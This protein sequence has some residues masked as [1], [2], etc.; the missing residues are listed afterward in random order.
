[1]Q[2]PHTQ[3]RCGLTRNQLLRLIAPVAALVPVAHAADVFKANNAD[4]LNI[5]TSWVGGALPTATDVA[6]F[7]STVVS[8]VPTE[9]TTVS[10]SVFR[11][12][13]TFPAAASFK[14][15]RVANA[16]G[17]NLAIDSYLQGLPALSIG[18]SGLDLS[19]AASG[20]IFQMYGQ[21][22]TLTA[23]QKWIVGDGATLDLTG[24]SVARTT[25]AGIMLQIQRGTTSTG[26]VKPS[27]T[28]G[29]GGL[30]LGG[31]A[32]IDGADFAGTSTD[33]S[34]VV[35]GNTIAGLYTANPTAVPP[36]VSGSY[37]V[38]DIVNSGTGATSTALRI[39]NTT[40]L[41]GIHFN[42]AHNTGLD[43][44]I[45]GTG[46]AR[47]I[48][49]GGGGLVV[50]PNVGAHNVVFN[51]A[52]QFRFGTNSDFYIHQF[53]TAGDLVL[54]NPMNQSNGT[55]TR[56]NKDGP[57]RL[58]IGSNN[59]T[60]GGQTTIFEGTIQVGN[61]GAAGSINSG[62]VANFGTLAFNRTDAWTQAN[63]IS[64]TGAIQML[65]TGTLTLSGTNTFTGSLSIN[66]G[67]VAF[68]ATA[69]LGAATGPINFNGGGLQ[70]TGTTNSTDIS[71]RTV[72]LASTAA[73]D[74]GANNVTFANPVGNSGAGGL[75]K[76]GTGTLTLAAA[77]LYSGNTA[78]TS[79]GLAV[80]NSTGS[81]TGSGNVSVA[82]SAV[83]SGTGTISG[84]V[85]VALGGKIKPGVSGVGTLTVGGL[86]M[87]S[88]SLMDLEFTSLSSFDKVVV[89]GTNGLSLDGVSLVLNPT[90]TSNSLSTL[91]NYDVLQYAGSIGGAGVSS[92]NVFNPQPGLSY[93]FT[94]SGGVVTLAVTNNGV[95]PEW[96]AGGS[97]SWGGTSNWSDPTAA[98][99]GGN[100]TAV[101]SAALGSVAT[102]TLDGDRQTKG[103]SFGGSGGYTIAQGTGGSLTLDNG[104]TPAG[105]TVSAG[106]HTISAP[107]ILNSTLGA[108]V[109]AGLNLQ[110]SG[111]VSGS[112]GVNKAGA[113]ILDLTGNNSFSGNVN[114]VAGILGFA[115][116]SSLGSGTLTLSGGA[117]RY[118]TGNTADIS[119]KVI[120]FGINGA[121]IDTNGNSLTLVNPIGNAG[122]G[123]FTKSGAGVLTLGA[124]NT[125]TGQTFVT[126]G[127]LRISANANLGDP[128]TGAK[129]TLDGS[130]LVPTTTLTLDN[131]GANARALAIGGSGAEINV[132]TGLGLTVPGVMTGAGT[133]LKSGAGDLTLSGLNS[134]FSGAVTIGAGAVR[135]GAVAASGQ[136]GLGT[137][138]ITFGNGTS[139]YLNGQGLTDN[140]TSYG[141][142]TNALVVSTG[143][144]ANLYG[145]QRGGF[146]GVVTGAG[147]LNL[148]VDGTRFDMNGIWPAFTGVMNVSATGSGTDDYRLN[149]DHNLSAATVNIGAGVQ[150]YQVNNPPA[151]NTGSIHQFGA[152]NV[153]AAATLA[154]N[155]VGGR[156][157]VY[158]IG[159][160]NANSVINGHI[161]GTLTS[162]A[163]GYPFI[164]KVG[165][166]TLTI[167]STG[168]MI[169]TSTPTTV[170]SLNV[171]AGTLKLMGSI[172]R[173]YTGIGA[174]G[175]YGRN[176]NVN[177]VAC[178]DTNTLTPPATDYV[179]SDPGACVVAAGATLAGNGRFGGL[180]TINGTLRPDA[181]GLLGGRLAFTNAATLTLTASAVTQFDFS[182]NSFTGISC[183]AASGV[184]VGGVLKVN[185]LNTIYNGSYTL[186]QMNGAP[187]GAFT[188]VTITTTTD[189]DVPLTDPTATGVWTGTVGSVTYTFTRS[190]G[191]LEVSGG[192]TVVLPSAVTGLAATAGNAQVAL[193]W[194]ASSN[195]DSYLVKRSTVASGPYT[196][197]NNNAALAYTDTG[198]T[199]GTTYYYVVEAKNTLGT[200]GNSAEVFATP[201]AAPVLNGLETWRQAQ[202]G[203]GATNTGSAA[204]NA[205]PDGDGMVNFLEYATNHNPLVAD[206]PA[207]LIGT[208]SGSLTLTY[209]TVLD[210]K[211]TYTVQGVNDITG[212]PV[213]TT[214]TTATGTAAGTSVV[215]DSQLISASPRRFLRLNVGYT[216]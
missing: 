82:N 98:G 112:G 8:I 137:G 43:W 74:I 32:T 147:T 61:G 191:V 110:I 72:T 35:Q 25:A 65:G 93:A 196:T 194:N 211:I 1:M 111:A 44:T 51:G 69:N 183:D 39:G 66:A 22:V 145:P 9:D 105:V 170:N 71:T 142:L 114:V 150:V 193:S 56:L 60:L 30:L 84:N 67:T 122:S 140:N 18:S 141:G 28:F 97:G 190:T 202:F 143:V 172:E 29:T 152:L 17:V 41:T 208:A 63:V 154:G 180:T 133:F 106:N 11:S 40:N 62:P 200:S 161:F 186:F 192:A 108:T 155:P 157:N 165:T 33:Q 139:L 101:F 90:G 158:Q 135:F 68:G 109:G 16:V 86:S 215:P 178:D 94:A 205:D 38:L 188:G 77:N 134:G 96:T 103:L 120:T 207:A 118:D 48:N 89:T 64:G 198:L 123:S 162:F 149:A 88:G 54:N 76:S 116:S 203:S 95:L 124:A 14:G 159:A 36:T 92:L 4:A 181:T 128:A 187:A 24:G 127:S 75:T 119:S 121:T 58:I 197:I 27:A 50:G 166:G 10:P 167:T 19:A 174:D 113:G 144:T 210:T 83:L 182:N 117:L 104:L 15:I 37:T 160:S 47:N 115:N 164:T 6:V 173:F 85:S 107:V 212:T 42:T 153:D 99:G 176:L 129:L 148:S 100:Y 204:D 175:I 46:T 31:Y 130:V 70:W 102:I 136:T 184:T 177:P 5:A 132:G 52:S 146:S 12:Y 206:G 138:S 201:T 53:N 2:K 34:Q 49:I 3:Y 185:F 216:P 23:S 78:I 59:A 125:Y 57:G 171:N 168:N 195:T 131:A 55:G 213:W 80:T 199:N 7:D 163:W 13:M 214:V 45:D 81:G 209:N 189:T 26:V 179:I 21:A 79:G 91:G 20:T 126:G 169:T 156:Y 87:A 151:N 73:L